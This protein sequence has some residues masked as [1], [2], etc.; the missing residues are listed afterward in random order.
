MNL[1]ISS[2]SAPPYTVSSS[3]YN[4]STG[5]LTLNVAATSGFTYHVVHGLLSAPKSTWAAVPG[6]TVTASSTGNLPISFP[7]G[8]Y[9]A[10]QFFV[11]VS[12]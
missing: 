6:T 8:T 12:P 1:V 5:N 11:V 9:G 10:E 7:I 3:T 4:A 2:S